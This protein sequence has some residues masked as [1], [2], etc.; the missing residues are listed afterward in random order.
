[1]PIEVKSGLFINMRK[2]RTKGQRRRIE[3]SLRVLAADEEIFLRRRFL[4]GRTLDSLA[5]EM[6]CS[7]PRLIQLQ[8]EAFRH[9]RNLTAPYLKGWLTTPTAITAG[10]AGV[11]RCSEP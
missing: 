4:E 9:L 6:G 8:Q 5:A 2:F 11:N 3:D 1:M 7:K 10:P